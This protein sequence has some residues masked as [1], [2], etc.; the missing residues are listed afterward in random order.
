MT[1]NKLLEAMRQFDDMTLSTAFVY[2]ENITL[3]GVDVTKEW[4]TA[5]EQSAN[6][7]KAYRKGYYD[8]LE[9]NNSMKRFSEELVRGEE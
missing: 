1:K 2:A 7:E 9:R 5:T 3:F 4:L 6:L 8:A